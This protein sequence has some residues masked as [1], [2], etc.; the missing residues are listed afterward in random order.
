MT[1]IVLMLTLHCSGHL[2][3][4]CVPKLTEYPTME[5]C[6]AAR[7]DTASVCFKGVK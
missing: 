6:E 5:A 3:A 1:V 4:K 7:G 2:N